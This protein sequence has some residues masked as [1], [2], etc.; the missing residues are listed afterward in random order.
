VEFRLLGPVELW[1]DDR[2]CELGTAK[3]RLVL[4]ILLLNPG[5]L[6]TT[7]A[8]IDHVWDTGPPAKPRPSLYSYVTRLRDRLAQTGGEVELPSRSGGYVLEVDETTIDVHRFQLLRTQARA[9]AQSGDDEHAIELYREASKLWRGEP[10]ADLSGEWVLR[11]RRFIEDQLLAATFERVDLELQRGG[12]SDLVGELSTLA[13]RYPYEEQL[14]ERLMRVLYGCGRQAEALQVYRRTRARLLDEIGTEP[15]PRLRKLH[16]RIVQGDRSLLYVQATRLDEGPPNT[17]PRD[18]QL[19]GR[20]TDLRRLLEGLPHQSP[21]RKPAGPVVNVITIDGMPGV[22][23]TAVAVHLAHELAQYYPD[24]Q[25]FLDLHAH[26]K[27]MEPVDPATALGTLLRSLGVP[28]GRIPQTLDDRTALWRAQLA[29]SRALVV[30]DDAAE[31]DQVLPL[32]PGSPGCLTIVTSRRRL[33]GLDDVRSHSLDILPHRDAAALFT[34]IVGPGRPMNDKDLA[35]V[36]QRCGRLPLGIS[37]A[38]SRLRHHSAWT[39]ADLLARLEHDNRRLDEL[40]AA[41]R[42]V[43]TVFEISYREL[44]AR[45]SAAFRL[46]G[47]HPGPTFTAH[48]AASLIR[49]EAAET[50]SIL[51]DLHERH[52]LNELERGRFSFHDLLQDYALRLAV[53]ETSDQERRDAIRRILDFYVAGADRADRLLYP[54]RRRLNIAEMHPAPS[55]PDLTTKPLAQRWLTTEFDNLLSVASYAGQHGWPTHVAHFALVLAAHLESRGYWTEAAAL[56]L[57]A[58]AAWAEIGDQAGMARALADLSLV[59]FRSGQYDGALEQAEEALGIHRS[60]ADQAGEAEML[61]HIGVIRWH[62]SRFTEAL[63]NCRAALRIWQS[64]NDRPGI[65]RGLDHAAIYLEYLG[66]YREASSNRQRALII[67]AQVGDLHGQQMALNN[68]GDLQLRLG[69]VESALDYYRRAAAATSEMGR[70]HEAIWMGNMASINKHT[71]R[72]DDALEGYRDALRI[73]QELGDPRGQIETLIGIGE[74][75]Q[76]LGK[77]SEALIH[78]EKARS[79]SRDISERYEETKALRCIGS[80]LLSFGRY[81]AALDHFKQA[82]DLANQIGELFEKAKALEGIGSARFYLN[83]QTHARFWKQAYS[84]YK[85]LGTKEASV[86]QSYLL[87]SDDTAP[88]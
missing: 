55:L 52:L 6:V 84:L 22:G 73:H 69:D 71:K 30:L 37:I 31:S 23:K 7:E 83:D 36:V 86:V 64:L 48:A 88:Q 66:R 21:P 34:N 77:Y 17:L 32:L 29:R 79:I 81:P 18:I 3:E 68:M 72:F 75:F 43:A 45:Q 47:L 24:A 27:G 14:I 2:R 28:H 59:Q 54:Q 56:H 16:E 49:A 58:S 9:I 41:D 51:D 35:A 8:L 80:A 19:T 38:G 60:M 63:A 42:A 78:Y 10:L 26:D 46:L 44:S 70:Q 67:Y 53:L 25:L 61:D 82:L 87:E 13:A 12:H 20:E 40:R 1:A 11:T 39:L 62:Q 50:E 65:A 33:V 57:R 76:C 74:T 85:R 15:D 5:Q 4:A